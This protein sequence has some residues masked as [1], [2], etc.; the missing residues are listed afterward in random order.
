MYVEIFKKEMVNSNKKNFKQ[1]LSHV[2]VSIFFFFVKFQGCTVMA[3]LMSINF[4]DIFFTCSSIFWPFIVNINNCIILQCMPILQQYVQSN[5]YFF[6]EAVSWSLQASKGFKES[7]LIFS[8]HLCEELYQ[9][10]VIGL[11]IHC[12]QLVNIKF[13]F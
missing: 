3:T 1:S 6:I 9:M 7:D 2:E 8:Y 12:N 5:Y 10:Y 11:L 4:M 13:S